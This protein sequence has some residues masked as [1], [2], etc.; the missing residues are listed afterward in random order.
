MK[1]S[2]KTYLILFVLTSFIMVTMAACLGGSQAATQT[3]VP[4][5]VGPQPTATRQR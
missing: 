4:A 2:T 3:E 5:A 1:R